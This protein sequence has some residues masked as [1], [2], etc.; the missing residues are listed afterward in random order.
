MAG[1][2]KQDP[3]Q[4]QAAGWT[5]AMENA[6]L[7]MYLLYICAAVSGAVIVWRLATAVLTYIRT[8]TNLTNDTQ[9]YFVRPS[10]NFAWIKKNLL[11]APLFRKRHNREFQLSSA[12]NVG[13][14]PTRFQFLFLAGYFAT[15]IAFCVI[16]I[17]FAGSYTDACKQLRNRSGTLAVVNMIPLFFMAGRNNPL[18]GLLGISFDTFNLL[19]RWFGRIVVLE[20][21][22]H[23]FAFW[24]ASAASG[25]WSAALNTTV[26]KPFMMYGFIATLAF[27]VIFFQAASISRH[28]YYESFKILH[29]ILAALAIV[30][31]YYHL[32]LIK[33]P[34]VQLLFS[35]IPIWVGDR[36]F[37][38]IS[39][40]YRNFGKGG[41]KTLVEALPGNAVRLTVTMARPW[42]FRPGQHAYLYL[43]SISFWQ[44]HPFSLA[45]SEEAEDLNG[46]K[47]AMNRQ[48]VLAMRKT[49]M[50]FV[51]RGRTGMTHTLYQKAAARPDG[52]FLTTCLVEGPYGGQHMMH[53]YGTVM[54]FAGGVGVTHA[55]PHVRDLV[56]GYANNTI[57]TRKVVLVWIIQSPEHLEWIRPWMTEILAMDKRRDVLRIMLFVSR[58]RSTKEIHSPSST[59]Q[60]FPGRPNI[61]T[62]ISMEAEQQVGTMGVSVCGPGALSDEVRQAVRNKQFGTSIDFIEEAFSW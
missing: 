62:L 14:L 17:P 61:D 9:R 22:C 12:V 6:A 7:S 47:L 28:A 15:N 31:L 34:Q 49:S 39:V 27:V 40:A 4:G 55:V 48:D 36:I 51:I 19:H 57:A 37:R 54:L 33:L 20:A 42:T 29:I 25:G 59:V 10:A 1:E 46:D 32:S 21:V 11:Y 16:N 45:W 58:P 52:R 3:G 2:G 35:I 18:I 30:G 8:V 50:S 53:S 43:P 60:M 26:T 24:A 23:T 41:T 5:P 56:T 44:S 13:T 38:F